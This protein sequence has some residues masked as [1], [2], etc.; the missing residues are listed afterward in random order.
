M[1]VILFTYDM[2][3]LHSSDSDRIHNDHSDDDGDGG[4]Q[5]HVHIHTPHEQN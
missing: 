2:L 5:F 4:D 1:W 3:S